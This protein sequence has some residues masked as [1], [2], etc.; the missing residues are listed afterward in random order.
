MC[1]VL[2]WLGKQSWYLGINGLNSVGTL[3]GTS[4]GEARRRSA[5]SSVLRGVSSQPGMEIL[6]LMQDAHGGPLVRCWVTA[7]EL[8]QNPSKSW[9]C[10]DSD[11]K[12]ALCGPQHD[13]RYVIFSTFFGE[14]KLS[15]FWSFVLFWSVMPAYGFLAGLV[16]PKLVCCSLPH[17]PL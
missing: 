2:D 17:C 14:V 10:L 7:G 3:T 6:T 1:H 11:C 13:P 9:P 8:M 16:E 15:G 4:F 5:L 12:P